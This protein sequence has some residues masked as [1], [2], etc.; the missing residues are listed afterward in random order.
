MTNGP[1]HPYHLDESTLICRDI[2]S[3]FFHIFFFHF[4]MKFMI[5]DRIA[6][7]VTPRS[8]ASH[9]RLF[10]RRHIWG[11]SVCLCPIKGSQAYII[12]VNF[13]LLMGKST[14]EIEK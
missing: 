3:D 6:Q 10:L 5:A 2:R 1:L 8:E 13:A 9:L 11:Y 4:S 7:D 12:W 14:K